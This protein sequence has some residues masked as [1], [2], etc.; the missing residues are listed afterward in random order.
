[1]IDPLDV[2]QVQRFTHVVGP[3]LL[4][5]MR[6]PV[7]PLRS[8]ALVG[9]DEQRRRV[10]DLGG[11]Q[12]DPDEVL[13]QRQRV[14]Q[15]LRSHLPAVLALEGQD[16]VAGEAVASRLG[17]GLAVPTDHGLQRHAASLMHGGVEGGLRTHHTR[18]AGRRR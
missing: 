13:P 12:P 15:H 7:Q 9:V 3:A 8:S 1:M 17:E 14:G 4:A 11:V 5:R 6:H 2:Q 16:Q 18:L 10:A